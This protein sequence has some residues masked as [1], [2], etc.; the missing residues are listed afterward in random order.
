MSIPDSQLFRQILEKL[1]KMELLLLLVGRR[2]AALR[3][4]FQQ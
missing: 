1:R 4:P 2:L 3:R